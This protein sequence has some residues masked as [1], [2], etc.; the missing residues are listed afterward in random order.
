[1][2]ATFANPQTRKQLGMLSLDCILIALSFI[3]AYVFRVYVIDQDGL[4]M[5]LERLSGFVPV[6]VLIHILALY[7]FD[8][9]NIENKKPLK[10]MLFQIIF[11]VCLATGTIALFSY[12]FPAYKLGRI[13][14]SAHV[15]LAIWALIT[16]R[17]IF[18]A[19]NQ[20]RGAASKLLI[21]GDSPICS[22]IQACLENCPISSYDFSGCIT[23]YS[24]NPG[25]VLDGCLY[26][27][28]LYDIAREKAINTIVVAHNL[29]EQDGLR[30]EL[31]R[32]KFEGVSI[33]DAPVFYKELQGKVPVSHVSD[34][35]FLFYNQGERFMPGYWKNIKRIMDIV[36]SLITLIL[37]SPIFL[38]LSLAIKLDSK[39]PVLFKQ[40]RLGVNE[41]P[42][43]VFKFR[44]MIDNAEKETGP[45]WSSTDD[46]RITRVGW[47]LRKTRLDEIPQFINV[48][49][50]EM[51]LVGPR[52]IRKHFADMLAEKFPFYRLRFLVKPGLTGW[53][54]VKGDYAGSEEG[55]FEKLQYELYYIQRQSLLMDLIILLKTIQ[56]VLSRPGE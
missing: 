54:Q 6:A 44:T 26:K 10:E 3:I 33:F 55:Q 25:A 41:K 22:E 31:M 1:M 13:V 4:P 32:L 5:V 35:W 19:M 36:L 37:L 39:G 47:F 2:N 24:R 8:L 40:E 52:P 50:G 23:D 7:V 48:L 34:S 21:I 27:K 28:S 46:P 30:E 38:I 45:K 11:S 12:L 9:Y 15:L 53:A 49:R 51:S 16:W 43:R 56:T 29:R 18:F 42:F 17:L 14:L 20:E